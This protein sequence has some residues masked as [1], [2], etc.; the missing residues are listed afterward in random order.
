[1][2]NFDK[3]KIMYNNDLDSLII[4]LSSNP[5]KK[6]AV[7]TCDAASGGFGIL[8]STTALFT[9]FTSGN[10]ISVINVW[11]SSGSTFT[12]T[13]SGLTLRMTCAGNAIYGFLPFNGNWTLYS[14]A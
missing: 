3:N 6:T 12:P 4:P 10:T 13:I 5:W 8:F 1:M 2:C 9:V 11:T 7:L 14:E